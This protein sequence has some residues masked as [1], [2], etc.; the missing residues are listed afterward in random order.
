MLEHILGIKDNAVV[1][2]NSKGKIQF[3]N[4]KTESLF[5]LSRE[6]L[7]DNDYHVLI[8]KPFRNRHNLRSG[9]FLTNPR[10]HHID[11]K[12]ELFCQRK[13]G[14]I[15]YI[16]ITLTPFEFDGE[17]LTA[18][19]IKD[20]S[21]NKIAE[22][23]IRNMVSVVE[24]FSDAIIT[25]D[26]KGMVTSWN[27]AAENL[28]G[29]NKNEIIGSRVSNFTNPK[30]EKQS[31]KF[32][33]QALKG[34]SFEHYEVERMHKNGSK[35]IVDVSIFPLK[36]RN[37]KI[38]GV[39]SISR[40]VTT[41]KQLEIA[42]AESEEKFR[43]VFEEGPVG[44][45]LVDHDF[46]TIQVNEEMTRILGYSEEELLSL[47]FP[48]YTHPDD[49]NKDLKLSKML[50]KG[51][52]PNFTLE[53][54]YITKENKLIWG[55][56]TCSVIRNNKGEILYGIGLIEDITEKKATESK[57]IKKQNDLQKVLDE[58]SDR[59]FELDQIVHKTSHDI[60]AP[61]SSILG[62]INVLQIENEDMKDDQYIKLIKSRIHKLDEI[63]KSMIKYSRAS[64]TRINHRKIDFDKLIKSCL[65]DLEYLTDFSQLEVDTTIIE[66]DRNFKSDPLRLQIIFSNIISN[67]YKFINPSIETNYLKIRVSLKKDAVR[68]TFLDNGI[69]IH[70]KHMGH[71]FDMFFRA[72]F[73][74]DGSG[75]GLY[76]VKQIVENLNGT[77]NT[78]S[79]LGKYTEVNITLPYQVD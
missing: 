5:Q 42:L 78:K 10:I 75:L 36:D 58:L 77:T 60:R 73:K 59:N 34:K 8:P 1:V 47:T 25:C 70:K 49:L 62:L 71:I 2:I 79:S 43:K 50:F 65:K 13:D 32:V 6:E 76:I 20:V 28:Y 53:K 24:N 54:R 30:N 69:G 74:S 64:R 3:V 18:A 56:L 15:F 52:I 4:P 16:D 17:V 67:S 66:R 21:D 44:I 23:T 29:Y 9:N 31:W 61:L 37:D 26:T 48:D 11:G 55:K 33:S 68:I 12:G 40:N 7:I 72:S 27:K 14:S 19:L 41:K 39:A 45:H 35:I 51:K 46:K 57:L 38:I 63:V 22:D